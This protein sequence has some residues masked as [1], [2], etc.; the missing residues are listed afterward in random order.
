MDDTMQFIQHEYFYSIKSMN[1]IDEKCD[2]IHYLDNR[3]TFWVY[4]CIV[5]KRR[6]YFVPVKCFDEVF[7]H[8][9]LALSKEDFRIKAIKK[10]QRACHN[11]LYSPK[12]KDGTIGLIPRLEFKKIKK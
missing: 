6:F 2:M 9:Y 8:M 1:W 3:T 11:W 7:V 12:C 4:T 10:I 5:Q